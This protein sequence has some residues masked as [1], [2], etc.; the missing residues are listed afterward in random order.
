MMRRGWRGGRDEGGR[1]G[2]ERGVVMVVEVRGLERYGHV[3]I[4]TG[5]KVQSGGIARK[6]SERTWSMR[7]L[8][9][10]DLGLLC[11]GMVRVGGY[12]RIL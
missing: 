6:A 2:P 4:P 11:H 12:G 3:M 9:L 8:H 1:A 7:R 5:E 10:S